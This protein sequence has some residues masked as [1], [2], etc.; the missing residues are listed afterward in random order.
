MCLLL[1]CNDIPRCL[2]LT[3]Q[4]RVTASTVLRSTRLEPKQKVANITSVG[5]YHR[6]CFQMLV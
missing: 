6:V 2:L 3:L 1:L 5:L 4:I